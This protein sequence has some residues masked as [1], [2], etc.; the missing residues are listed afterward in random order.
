M[1]A[2]LFACLLFLSAL[3]LT[4]CPPAPSPPAQPSYSIHL[5]EV[6]DQRSDV[7]ACVVSIRGCTTKLA[8]GLIKRKGP[9]SLLIRADVSEA[10]GA[11]G[12]AA[13][14]AAGAK[15]TLVKIR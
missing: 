5:N 15:A 4:G 11:L 8:E 2:S 3:L 13:L 9:R 7:I 14:K 10:E 1:R 12:V 6:G